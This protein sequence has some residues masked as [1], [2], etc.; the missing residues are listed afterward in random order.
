M[1]FKKLSNAKKAGFVLLV[2]GVLAGIIVGI[3]FATG[4]LGTV[5]PE[6]L[7]YDMAQYA[8]SYFNNLTENEKLEP[9]CDKGE[10]I[11][12]YL[13]GEDISE[14][15]E[16]NRCRERL[17]DIELGGLK[18]DMSKFFNSF[19]TVAEDFSS[20]DKKKMELY[21]KGANKYIKTISDVN[22]KDIVK[23]LAMVVDFSEL[24]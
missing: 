20:S 13:I 7:G 5:D 21:I 15:A 3:L 18:K 17:K 2:L 22:H 11:F 16:V 19:P 9:L 4:V 10:F 23:T 8:H 6:Q 1:N 24:L 12:N 14:L